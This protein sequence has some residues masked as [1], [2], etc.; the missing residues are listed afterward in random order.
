MREMQSKS[1]K[2]TVKVVRHLILKNFWEYYI[3]DDPEL[4]FDADSDIQYAY[5]VGVAQEFGTISMKEFKPF[6]I[7]DTTKLEEVA[8]APN[9]QWID[10]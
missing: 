3:V 4:E 10:N 5:A 9:W 8:P 6:I 1:G 7:S 2:T